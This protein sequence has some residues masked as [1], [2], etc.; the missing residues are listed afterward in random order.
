[1][2]VVDKNRIFAN[3]FIKPSINPLIAKNMIKRLLNLNTIQKITL[4]LTTLLMLPMS[5]LAGTFST[6]GNT[7]TYDGSYTWGNGSVLWTITTSKTGLSSAG[8]SSLTE[9]L[10]SGDFIKLS[11]TNPLPPESDERLSSIRIEGTINNC[12]ISFKFQKKDGSVIEESIPHNGV[13]YMYTFKDYLEWGDSQLLEIIISA[14]GSSASCNISN[15]IFH[16]KSCSTATFAWPNAP[17][18]EYDINGLNRTETNG[19]VKLEG[20]CM[21]NTVFSFP[22]QT[23]DTMTETPSITYTSSNPGTFV[24]DES[25]R[26]IVNGTGETTITAKIEG[27]SSY[28]FEPASYSYTLNITGLDEDYG[29][30]V[31]GIAVTSSNKNSITGAGITSGQVSYNP[32]NHTLSLNGVTTSMIYCQAPQPLTIEIN[33]SNTVGMIVGYGG[34]ENPLTIKK[35]GSSPASLDINP[36]GQSPDGMGPVF[37][38]SSCTWGEGLYLVAYSNNA[39]ISGAYYDESGSRRQFKHSTNNSI[40]CDLPIISKASCL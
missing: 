37:H 27:T 6:Q 20:H 39:S 35:S 23:E 10:T 22:L 34:D 19:A 38:F 36:G 25:G 21:K 15:I 29:L 1:M 3:I 26:V 14:T 16:T 13:E 8:Q 5:S 31:G 24:V 18:S 9:S 17:T 28:Y 32:E 11:T 7:I 4:I 30:T 33:G 2:E 40:D 12:S